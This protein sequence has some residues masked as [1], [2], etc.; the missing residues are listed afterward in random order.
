MLHWCF[1]RAQRCAVYAVAGKLWSRRIGMMAA[2]LFYCLPYVQDLSQ[3]ARIDLATTFFATLA[4]G[5]VLL[6][7]DGD[8]WVRWPV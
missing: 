1:W 6:A 5:G 7:Y 3:T 4:F 8:Q 2:A